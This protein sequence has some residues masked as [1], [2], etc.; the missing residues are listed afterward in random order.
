M[1]ENELLVL[2]LGSSVFVFLL[3]YRIS[4]RRL[5]AHSVLIT[6]FICIWC[7]W[8]A[9]VVEHFFFFSFFN[10]VEHLAYALNG[11]FLFLWCYLGLKN[12]KETASD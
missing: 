5:P 4:L 12:G 8:L 6:S 7:A 1:H 9:T 11:L 10:I 3:R 2:L